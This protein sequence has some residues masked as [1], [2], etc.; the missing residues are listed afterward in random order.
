MEFIWR[1]LITSGNL[2]KQWSYFL[3][4]INFLN[5]RC[6]SC[7]QWEKRDPIFHPSKKGPTVLK[8]YNFFLQ[9]SFVWRLMKNKVGVGFWMLFCFISSSL[10]GLI[11]FY[12]CWLLK[13]KQL[14]PS[15]KKYSSLETIEK[16]MQP[17]FI[18][19]PKI[20][21]NNWVRCHS[22]KEKGTH[23]SSSWCCSTVC[24]LRTWNWTWSWAWKCQ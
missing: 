24:P 4:V 19:C 15:H 6:V 16:M 11:T 21:Q 20:I 13:T 23:G 14:I 7:S 1:G 17:I 3:L 8:T 9:I 12:G 5:I 10:A 2:Y 22:L 18:V